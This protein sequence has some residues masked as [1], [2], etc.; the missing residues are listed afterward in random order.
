MTPK[1]GAIA[2][3]L[4]CAASAAQATPPDAFALTDQLFAISAEKVFLL[5]RGA[6]NL[7][8]YSTDRRGVALVI[9]DRTTGAE[10][11][12]PVYRSL[13]VPDVDNHPDA[14]RTRITPDTL[15]ATVDP[16]ALLR[17]HNAEAILTP[18]EADASPLA[19][20]PPDNLSQHAQ[21]AVDAYAA[22]MGDY[23]R[24][25]TLSLPQLVEGA[26]EPGSCHI[27][28]SLTLQDT[29]AAQPAQLIHALCGTP[30]EDDITAAVYL[31]LPPS[32]MPPL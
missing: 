1:A 18:T 7:G 28:H 25:G 13:R 6:D 15:P 21:K 31:L 11:T 4:A 2:L 3:A 19:T 29:S 10:E 24:M 30:E 17:D 14:N 9:V 32:K 22:V 5:R 16:Y 12:L 27:D 20:S 23:Q 8:L 26:F